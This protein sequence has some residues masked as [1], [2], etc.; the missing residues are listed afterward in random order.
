MIFESQYSLSAVIGVAIMIAVG[1]S[2]PD[3]SQIARPDWLTAQHTARL[4][5]GRPAI[6][7]YE[8]HVAHRFAAS[9][10]RYRGLLRIF[11]SCGPCVGSGWWASLARR[12]GFCSALVRLIPSMTPIFGRRQ[13]VEFTK[14]PRKRTRFAKANLDTDLRHRERRPLQQAPGAIHPAGHMVAMRRRAEGLL[15]GA[16]KM[17]EAQIDELCEG[18]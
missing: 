4:P 18:G 8:S 10:L 3:F 13:S 17:I 1:E 6:H 15:E 14:C 2:R 5:A 16:R 12:C 7:Q 11:L 9:C